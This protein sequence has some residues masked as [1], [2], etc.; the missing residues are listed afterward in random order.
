MLYFIFFCLVLL[1]LAV[2]LGCYIASVFSGQQPLFMRWLR[3]LELAV[4]RLCGIDEREEMTWKQYAWSFCIFTLLGIAFLF[5]LEIIQGKL[6]FNPQHLG[7][8]RWDTALNTAISFATNTNWQ[9]YGGETT[10]A[11]FTQMLGLTTQNFVSAAAG[12]APCIALLRSFM[13][14][15]CSTIGNFWVD[16]TRSILYILLPLSIVCSIILVS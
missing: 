4:Y 13:R 5:I 3:P 6:P 2:P 9:S 12:I 16:V 14:K 1:L 15:S 8:V 10:M 11:Y 7:A